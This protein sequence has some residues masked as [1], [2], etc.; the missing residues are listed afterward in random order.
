[1]L[2]LREWYM[3]PNGQVPAYEWNFSD[4]NPPVHAWACWRVY[5]ISRNITGH[6]D[7]QW[8]EEVFQKLLLNFTWW[9]NRKDRGGQNVFEGGFLGLD[10]IGVF[11]RSQSFPGGGYIEQADGT[12]WMGMFCLNML[13]I[14][15]ELARTR[16][17][18]ESIATKFLEHF[19]YIAHAINAPLD[20]GG[21]WD[22]EDGFFYDKL[23][24]GDGSMVPLKVR[25]LVGLIP[26]LAV[27]TLDADHLQAL[28]N[29]RRRME[30]FIRYRPNLTAS[31]ASLTEP[32]VDGR[33]L[34]TIV[35]RY[36]LERILP[37]MFDPAQ[38]LSDFGLRSMSRQLKAEPFVFTCEGERH[39]VA[40]E[41]G[42]S[43]AAMFG[44]N[45]NWRGPVWFPI[46][47]LMIESLE[48]YHHY[49]GDSLQ[50]ECP[51]YS[52]Q[53]ISLDKAALDLGKRLCAIFLRDN[54]PTGKGRRP[55]FGDVPLFQQGE[56]WRDHIPFF[57]YF[58]GDTGR[59][60]GASHQTGWT[61]LVARLLHEQAPK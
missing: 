56:H 61:A 52:G 40:Y 22:T 23:H 46:N 45:S 39:S 44:G 9:V 51:R 47:Y 16:P 8:L 18:Y 53:P 36:K 19:I 32:G 58:H 7:V 29:F 27:E 41:P 30:W 57:E 2:M 60:L 13:A 3:H 33:R 10:N 48:K 15:L 37:R 35:D 5:K 11:D 55:V 42:E 6:A 14:S 50:T 20:A 59:G 21:L 25:S 17:A 31:V 54:S 12:A 28:P 4:V 43:T 38:F 1:M 26:L 49:Y 24:L 34:L